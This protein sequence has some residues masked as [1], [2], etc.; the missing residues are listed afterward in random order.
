MMQRMNDGWS[1]LELSPDRLTMRHLVSAPA[2]RIVL[3]A[4]NPV[5]WIAGPMWPEV[6]RVLHVWPD[7]E[8]NLHRRTTGD[9]PPRWPQTHDWD[10]EDGP[11]PA[12]A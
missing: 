4:I 11:L 2:W 1:V 12:R 5:E 7:K 10:I 6:H 3:A 9:I 8:G